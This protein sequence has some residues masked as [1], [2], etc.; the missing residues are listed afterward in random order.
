MQYSYHKTVVAS[1]T[2]GHAGLRGFA[3]LQLGTP[4]AY[5]LVMDGTKMARGTKGPV[6]SKSQRTILDAIQSEILRLGW[7][8]LAIRI[9]VES[10]R[11]LAALADELN[12]A[13]SLR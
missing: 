1:D 9:E 2:P 11:T 13:E 7:E 6:W 8:Q 5:T 3:H 4:R 12:N 10:F